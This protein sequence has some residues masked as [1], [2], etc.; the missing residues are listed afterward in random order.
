VTDKDGQPTALFAA[1]AIG[2]PTKENG[3]KVSSDHDTFI[4]YFQLKKNKENKNK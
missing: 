2:E 1:A 3:A 4:V